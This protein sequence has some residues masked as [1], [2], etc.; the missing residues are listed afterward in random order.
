MKILMLHGINH[1]MFGKRDPKQYGTITLD[2]INA[3]LE[4]LGRDLG[5]SIENFQTNDEGAMCERIHQGYR[6]GV[7][8]VLINAGAWTHYSYG[9]RD[10]LAILTC[11]IVELHMSNIHAREAFRHV[12][13][14]AEI[15]TG[16]IC[17]FGAD[18]YLLALRAAV[19]AAKNKT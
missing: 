17:G 18:S 19:T 4:T 8:G 16:Q 7:D 6:D 15:V 2:E 11:P 3:S 10:A 12:S 13:V 1:N 14:L 9:L 5:C